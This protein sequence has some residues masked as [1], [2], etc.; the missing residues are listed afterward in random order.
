MPRALTWM[1][2]VGLFLLLTPVAHAQVESVG[3]GVADGSG[4]GAIDFAVDATADPTVVAEQLR[5]NL[6]LTEGATIQSITVENGVAHI[7]F[8]SATAGSTVE[9]TLPT[10]IAS[11]I[12]VGGA[13]GVGGGVSTAAL[14]GG[15]A[16]IVGGGVVGGLAAA[17]QFEG[18][19]KGSPAQ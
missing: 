4:A 19:Q 5:A 6:Q 13:A 10:E 3:T 18:Q 11:A 14:V 9:A 2:A 8:A 17:G 16:L 7:E 15:G 12:G 1:L